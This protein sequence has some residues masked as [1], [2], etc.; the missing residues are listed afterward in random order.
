MTENPEAADSTTPTTEEAAIESEIREVL[1]NVV[2]PEIG[3]DVI[4]LGLIRGIQV[5]PEEVEIEMV[6]TT[7]FCPYGGVL[8]QQ[9]NDAARAVVEREVKVTLLD[10]AWSPEMMEG[11]N[12]SE[13]GLL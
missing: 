11:G 4:T 1:R 5:R 13:W 3:L 12:W 6:F 9:V 7:P 8:L 2:D 10:Q